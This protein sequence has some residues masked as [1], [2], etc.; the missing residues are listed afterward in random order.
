MFSCGSV[1]GWIFYYRR[2]EALAGQT[3]IEISLAGTPREISSR[4]ANAAD[5][6]EQVTLL[7]ESLATKKAAFLRRLGIA[8]H[9]HDQIGLI[10]SADCMT[11]RSTTNATP[12]GGAVTISTSLTTRVARVGFDKL[13][14][15]CLSD[16]ALARR[17]RL[18]V[19]WLVE[20]RCEPRFEAAVV[21]TSIALESLLTFYD[22]ESLARCLSERMALLLF[23]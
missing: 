22:K 21:K 12:D 7:A 17:L 23:D 5:I 4:A 9:R 16:T 15:G 2:I 20:S 10:R 3:V 1:V 18:A 19:D 13:Y 6:A 14:Q 8:P 11:I